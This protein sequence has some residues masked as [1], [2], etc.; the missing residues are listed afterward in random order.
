MD[1]L[2]AWCGY[3]GA[4]VLVAGPVYQAA[5][6]LGEV[7]VDRSAIRSL[8]GSVPRP[9]GVSPWWW[10]LPPVAYVL[11]SRRQ[12]VWQQQV[13]AALS[14]QQRTEFLTYSN[15][16]AGWFIVGAGAA[17]IGVQ[18]AAELVKTEHWPSLITI[19]LV[20]LAAAAALAYTVRRMQLTERALHA[21]AATE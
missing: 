7:K 11:T 20:V 10:L 6:E 5:V 3:L 17:L 13:M 1:L 21:E 14:P 15:K 12:A 19:L 9:E 8:A 18:Q 16:A 2:V 4:W